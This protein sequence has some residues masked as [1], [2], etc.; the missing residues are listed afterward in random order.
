MLLRSFV[1]PALVVLSVALDT[2]VCLAATDGSAPNPVGGGGSVTLEPAPPRAARR[3]HRLVFACRE[4]TLAVFSD[5]PCGEAS[6]LRSLEVIVPAA[7]GRP[8]TTEPDPARSTTKPAPRKD[9]QAVAHEDAA[10]EKVAER[11]EHLQ[12]AVG[13]IDDR[14]RAGYPAREAARLWQRW[15][16]A[17]EQL[18]SAQC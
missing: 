2:G 1:L 8:P 6:L 5:R 3:T 11:C 13:E 14:M 10:G 18:R 4:G 7:T 17:K 9:A 12:K 15:R 16:A